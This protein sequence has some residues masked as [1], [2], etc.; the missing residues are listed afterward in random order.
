MK[1]ISLAVAT[2]GPA[3]RS[4]PHAEGLA[5]QSHLP[6]LVIIADSDGLKISRQAVEG[7]L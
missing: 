4:A 1:R 2:K 7:A 6:D 5:A 3:R